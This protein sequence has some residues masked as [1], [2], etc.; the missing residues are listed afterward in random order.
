MP[1]FGYRVGIHFAG[2]AFKVGTMRVSYS[3]SGPT[4]LNDREL[5]PVDQL[6]GSI[7]LSESISKHESSFMLG[8]APSFRFNLRIRPINSLR[9]LSLVDFFIYK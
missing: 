8:L 2:E 5:Y 7:V 3:S 9:I 1:F 4:S 6:R